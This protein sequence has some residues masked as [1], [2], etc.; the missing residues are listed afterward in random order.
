[1]SQQKEEEMIYYHNPVI[2]LQSF[3][4]ILTNK[5]VCLSLSKLELSK[6]LMYEF[7]YDYLKPK[8]NE[9][10]KVCYMDTDSF[11]VYIKTDAIYKEVTEDVERRFDT[12]NY[13]LDRSL[14]KKKKK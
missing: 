9:K 10:A 8:F 5:L 4:Q 13:E 6:I 12:S 1:M 14:P 11:I 2:T 7:W 3:P